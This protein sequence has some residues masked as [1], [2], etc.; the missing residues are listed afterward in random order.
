MKSKS[1]RRKH[2]HPFS[3]VKCATL[4]SVKKMPKK[5][6]IRLAKKW[7]GALKGDPTAEKD[8]ELVLSLRRIPGRKI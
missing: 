2:A 8:M 6:W 7:A 4:E 5:E 1:S 3:G